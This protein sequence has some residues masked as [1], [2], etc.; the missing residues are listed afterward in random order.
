MEL[1]PLSKFSVKKMSCIRGCEKP[2]VFVVSKHVA[3]CED[4]VNRL[5][6]AR[7]NVILSNI[8]EKHK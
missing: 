2:A 4:C 8:Q 6:L 1:K 5:H 3:Y 7:T